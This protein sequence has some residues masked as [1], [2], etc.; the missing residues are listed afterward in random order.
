MVLDRRTAGLLGL[1]ILLSVTP[2]GAQAN[3]EVW[4]TDFSRHTVPLEEIVSGGPPK[5]GIPALDDP[6]FVSVQEADD[7]LANEGP[8]A[9]VRISGEVKARLAGARVLSR[10]T[11]SLW[12]LSGDAVQGPL[13]GKRLDPVPHGNHFW[14]S[15]AVFKPETQII[16]GG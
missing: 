5:D 2:L 14:F 3:G 6:V 15:W 1:G 8:V 4:I 10:E 9:V 11:G 16:R 7:W 12:T 13:E